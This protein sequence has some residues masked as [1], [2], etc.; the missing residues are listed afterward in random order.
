MEDGYSLHIV[1]TQGKESKL[2]AEP[3]KSKGSTELYSNSPENVE[4]LLRVIFETLQNVENTDH[5]VLFIQ[6]MVIDL[7]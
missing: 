3:N 6:S 5:I 7:Q 4:S 2:F 1:H